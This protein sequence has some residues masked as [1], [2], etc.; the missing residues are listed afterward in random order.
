MY[1]KIKSNVVY[2]DKINLIIINI[3]YNMQN[4]KKLKN[5]LSAQTQCMSKRLILT[6]P[7]SVL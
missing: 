6:Q 1:L 7:S 4:R 5:Y 3:A 2:L